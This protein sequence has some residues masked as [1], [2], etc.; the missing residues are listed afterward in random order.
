M[1]FE[2]SWVITG[3][4]GAARMETQRQSRGWLC[5][6]PG[7]AGKVSKELR[8]SLGEEET[9][10]GSR[11]SRAFSKQEQKWKAVEFVEMGGRRAWKTQGWGGSTVCQMC[12][13]GDGYETLRGAV[14]E[15]VEPGV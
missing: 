14:R 2:L 6:D 5:L 3:A 1:T 10:A 9:E 13:R 7:G 12:Q 15:E 11:A 4:A 8:E